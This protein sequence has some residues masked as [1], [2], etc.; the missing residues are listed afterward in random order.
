[1]D[2]DYFLYV[3]K[4]FISY[5]ITSYGISEGFTES[6]IVFKQW[7][8]HINLYHYFFCY[9]KKVNYLNYIFLSIYIIC[10]ASI[11]TL[12]KEIENSPWPF[13][14]RGFSTTSRLLAP[15]H[16]RFM[17]EG[18]QSKLK[19]ETSGKHSP[20][21]PVYGDFNHK[22]EFIAEGSATH[23]KP[24]VNHFPLGK[25]RPEDKNTSAIPFDN[26]VPIPKEFH[27]KKVPNSEEFLERNK[28]KLPP[29][30]SKE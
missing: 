9:N 22:G 16:L 15:K 23:G 6:R 7:L 2:D 28:D 26:P 11:V 13:I 5:D 25:Q 17:H 29:P 18:Y 30:S 24:P 12:T 14:I 8:E 4:E 20:G 10:W 27:G 19:G 3:N 21:H 1:M